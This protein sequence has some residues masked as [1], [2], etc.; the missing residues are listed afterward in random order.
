[1]SYYIT[2]CTSQLTCPVCTGSLSKAN[3]AS[4]STSRISNGLVAPSRTLIVYVY[5][6]S[7][8]LAEQNFAFF[9]R[10]AVR[11][12]HDTDYYFILQEINKEAFDEVKLPEL[13]SNAHYIQHENKCFDIGTIGWFLFSGLVDKNAYKYF[14]FL[15]SSVRGPF[16]VSYYDSPIW[17]TIF[18]R[19]LNDHI[20]LV[21]CTIS[22]Q[23]SPH[24]Q[25]YLWAL[26]LK[27]LDFLLNNGTIFTCHNSMVDTIHNAE[28][29]ASR[30]LLD[31]GYEIDSLMTKYRGVDFRY[32]R[33][34]K[35]VDEANPTFNKRV[36]GI[37]L[38][39][40][41]VVFVKMKGVADQDLDNRERVNVYEAWV[42]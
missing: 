7:H 23:R 40:Y 21:G 22:C 32:N 4:I 29:G 13:P 30:L 39:P 11:Q 38:D 15:N 24:V 17:H 31:S 35:C 6:K 37:T 26:D 16:I 42:H 25:S 1:M 8:A 12:S 10:T 14:I 19:R 36:N 33:T 9:I 3:A 27:T 2:S 18:T 34:A 28:V 41:E 20:K 5:G